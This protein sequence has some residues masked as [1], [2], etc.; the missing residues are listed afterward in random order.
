VPKTFTL[1]RG[2]VLF[3]YDKLEYL[4]NRY[5]EVRKE[6]ALRGFNL[7]S[8]RELGSLGFD[9]EF[10]NDYVPTTDALQVIRTRIKERINMKPNWYRKTQH[11][12]I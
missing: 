10:Y 5:E 4:T 2:H 3:F 11:K 6:L 12:E 7:D 9:S 1:G 8:S